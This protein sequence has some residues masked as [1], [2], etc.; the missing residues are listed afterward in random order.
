MIPIMEV[1]TSVQGEGAHSGNISVFV[2][3]GGCN[4]TCKG[5]GV[6]YNDPNTNEVKLGCDS[7]YSV[8]S[9]YKKVWEYAETFEDVVAMIDKVMP[10]YPKAVLTRPDIVITGGEP[11]LY[12]KNTE[13]QKLI[14][15]Y[16]SRNHAVTIETNASKSINFKKEY[17][18]NLTFSMSVKLSN[19]GEPSHKRINIDNIT[20]MIESSP[21]SYLKFVVSKD[22]IVDEEKE[23][24]SILREIPI[25]ATVYLMPLGDTKE[26][27]DYNA[28]AVMELCIKKGF[29]YSDRVHI[30]IWDNLPGV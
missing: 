29:K 5:F 27:M 4:F 9:A 10:V 13:F 8:D 15:Y 17:H 12:W 7:Y 1:F 3:V 16:T 30:R 2:R 11:T 28:R 14:A 24:D 21:S 18:R 19:S 25:Y 23:I 26:S 22:N 6:S 20:N